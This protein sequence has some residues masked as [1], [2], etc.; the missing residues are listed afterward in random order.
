MT[1]I[2]FPM[3][4]ALALLAGTPTPALAIAITNF[5][6]GETVTYPVPIL[7]GEASPRAETVTVVNRS[8]L[9]R[10]R[11]MEGLAQEG[12]FVALAHLL[13][14]E[15][16]LVVSDGDGETSIVLRFEEQTNPY[17]VR[18]IYKTDRSGATDY[19]T[20]YEDDPQNYIE[21]YGVAMLL[22]QSATAEM[23]FQAGYD[24]RTFHMA[25]DRRGMP[26]IHTHIAEEDVADYYQ[27]SDLA[28]YNKTRESVEK[29]FPTSQA[30]NI[31]I[32]AFTRFMPEEKRA[33]GHTALGA[34]GLALFGSGAMHGWPNSL[35][36]VQRAFM[37]SAFID[38]ER[39]LDDSAFRQ[40][41]WGMTATTIGAVLHE[42]GHAFGMPHTVD[43]AG[44][45]RRGFD[46]INRLFTLE[47]P[48][49]R[50]RDHAERIT[51]DLLPVW[52]PA[53]AAWLRYSR[54]LAMQDR[55][56]DDPASVAI[57]RV[58]GGDHIEIE[59]PLGL[60]VVAFD[61]A[62][63]D[64]VDFDLFDQPD[65]APTRLVYSRMALS[66][67]I[68]QALRRVRAMDDQGNFSYF[69]LPAEGETLRRRG[70]GRP[71]GVPVPATPPADSS[72]SAR[73]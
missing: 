24:R 44:I 18:P 25:L 37:N 47:E 28:W 72:A 59:S 5:Q 51:P 43:N 1:R 30:H 16:L 41:Y 62:D 48:P 22:I 70:S 65:G 67:R 10:T 34:P 23:L 13:P 35:D 57:R 4:F 69:D 56:Y 50:G 68:G 15:N 40:T 64:V 9:R 2:V 52:C 61:Q 42:L 21:K 27:L 38:G 26:V 29:A 39:V 54:Y 19:Q 46:R 49:H 20:A 36:D 8:S 45:M 55:P 17:L 6:S 33:Y 14:G 58:E 11:E 66:E 63:G 53:N 31:V 3:L 12:R 71:A 7:Q 60:R 73:P 32:A